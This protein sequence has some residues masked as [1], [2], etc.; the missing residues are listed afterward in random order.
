MG[1]ASPGEIVALLDR[2]ID[3]SYSQAMII[4]D[5]SER[6]R[7]LD[8]AKDRLLGDPTPRHLHDRI[9]PE[10]TAQDDAY[11]RSIKT[12]FLAQERGGDGEVRPDNV[13]DRAGQEA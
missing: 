8:G 10:E 3:P 11:R 6:L 5:V 13:V 12:E 1:Y 7:F 4:A 2:L 9:G